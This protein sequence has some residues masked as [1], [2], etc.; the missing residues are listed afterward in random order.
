LTVV[1]MGA[2]V[3]TV[4]VLALSFQSTLRPDFSETNRMG[5]SVRPALE[6]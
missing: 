4:T 1:V 5:I 2:L 3:V 6:M